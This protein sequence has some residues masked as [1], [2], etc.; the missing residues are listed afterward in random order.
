M[1]T[2]KT[3]AAEAKV[4]RVVAVILQTG[5]VDGDADLGWG[6]PRS[7][8]Y[9]LPADVMQEKLAEVAKSFP[10]LWHFRIYDTVNDPQ[11]LIRDELSRTW[12]AFDDRLYRG[13]ANLRVQGW[14][15][16]QQPPATTLNAEYA[17]RLVLKIP[18]DAVPAAI[19]QGDFLDIPGMVWSLQQDNNGRPLAASL[20]LVD[21]QGEVW[22]SIDEP[23]GGNTQSDQPVRSIFQPMRLAIPE[24]TP[25]GSYR[26]ELVVYDP[27]TG[28]P[29]AATGGPLVAGAQAVLGNVVVQRPANPSTVDSVLADFGP[30][31][32][33]EASTP[34]TAVSPGD[35]IPLSLLWQAAP[36]YQPEPLVVVVQL[37]DKDG[38]VVAS[39]E[40]EPLAGRYP[41]TAVAVWR[42]GA[43]PAR[44]AVP[45]DVP[46]GAYQ[47]IVGLYRATDGQRLETSD[48]STGSAKQRSLQYQRSHRTVGIGQRQVTDQL[49]SV[50][51][52]SSELASTV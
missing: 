30:L 36:D 5:H 41:T 17:N 38:Q 28:Q 27:A 24:G 37:L 7:D 34:A 14:Q 19:V 40:E 25:P 22:A 1:T 46:P 10:R 43:R 51:R 6:D 50:P 23:I 26:L 11:G 29:L 15:A 13:E 45:D 49:R 4:R 48:G 39:L 31:R 18:A 35:E 3:S 52:L 21:D 42:D 9:A 33:V 44:L 2:R 16:A 32:L 12:T 47:L 20:R 8:F